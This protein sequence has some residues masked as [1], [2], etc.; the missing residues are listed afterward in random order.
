MSRFSAGS[1]GRP[2]LAN[3][4]STLGGAVALPLA[5]AVEDT[6]LISM[7]VEGAPELFANTRSAT[8]SAS[9]SKGSSLAPMATLRCKVFEL[10]SSQVSPKAD[11]DDPH[12]HFLWRRTPLFATGERTARAVDF[13]VALALTT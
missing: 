6:R 4:R 11:F 8:R 12:L 7:G 1:S 5:A 10:H 13:A 9:S 2:A 3:T